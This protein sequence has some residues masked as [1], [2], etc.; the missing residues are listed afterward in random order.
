MDELK[1]SANKKLR[2]VFEIIL[3]RL[4]E[5]QIE[6]WVFG[7]VSIAAYARGF[8]RDNKDVDIFVKNTD[9]EKADLILHDLCSQINLKYCFTISEER[10]KLEIKIN[11][12]ERFSM[13]PIYQEN[14][15]VI[16]LYENRY[17]GNQEYPN[18]ILK[19]VERDISGYRFFTPR[20][21]FI[22]EMFINHIKVRPDK[23]NRSNIKTDAKAIL[24]P[25]EY[26]ELAF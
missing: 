9:F 23:K 3:P 6:Y 7:G 17:G 21:E 10:P 18:Q 14:D 11:G 26:K 19:R 20:D 25:E 12:I 1:N 24:T 8:I 22:K 5:A 2:P 4:E 13:V 16:F 15:K